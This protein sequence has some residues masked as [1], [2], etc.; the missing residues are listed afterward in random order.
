M[1]N[2]LQDSEIREQYFS[3]NVLIRI[4]KLNGNNDSTDT[5]TSKSYHNH[6]NG[7]RLPCLHSLILT[8][9]W[10]GQF[11]KVM[12]TLNCVSGLQDS[13]KFSLSP[14]CLDEAM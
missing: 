2:F 3:G 4:Y 5:S 11:E 9:C 12:Q 6:A 10:F 1:K 14:E 8:R 7:G 13:R